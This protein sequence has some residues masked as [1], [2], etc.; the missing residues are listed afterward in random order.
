MHM[1]LNLIYKAVKR[2]HCSLSRLNVVDI[3]L[4]LKFTCSDM[5]AWEMST[6]QG[7]EEAESIADLLLSDLS[8]SE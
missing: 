4:G 3:D 8:T 5:A 2:S 6:F 7:K 1:N